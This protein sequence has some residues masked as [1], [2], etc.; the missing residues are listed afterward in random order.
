MIKT[1][2]LIVGGGPAGSSCAWRLKQNGANCLILDQHNFPRFK[3]CAGWITPDLVNDLEMNPSEYPY[4]FTTFTSFDISIRGFKF[5]LPTRQHAIRRYEFD[6]WLL[7]RAG[8]PIQNHTVKTITQVSDGYVIDGMYFGKYLVGAGGTHCPVYKNLFQSSNPREKG[9]LIVAQEAEFSYPIT[10]QRCRLWF[11]ENKLPGYAWYVP[12]ANGYVNVGLG[13]MAEQ[14]KT[15]GDSLKKHWEHLLQKLDSMG[16]IQGHNI[17]PSGHYYYLRQRP[18]EVRRDNAFIV[19]DAASLATL[20]MG[21]GIRPAVQS[22][23]LA[24]EAILHNSDYSLISIPK[25]SWPSL[26][27]PTK[28]R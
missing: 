15:N 2:V 10:D 21:E 20:D 16:L 7:H 3:P 12:K 24:A 4:S 13:G 26:I 11:L 9:F 8:A 17:N 27:H 28:H 1:D 14:L 23:L 25:Y 18:S 6:D 22:G 5:T 19:G